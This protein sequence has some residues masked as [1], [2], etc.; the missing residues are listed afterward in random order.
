M[1]RV[2]IYLNGYC[3]CGIGR[4]SQ[5]RDDS[6]AFCMGKNVPTSTNARKLVAVCI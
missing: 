5:R 4:N 6:E 3:I 1:E 2:L